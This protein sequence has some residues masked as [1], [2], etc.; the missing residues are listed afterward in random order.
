M[1]WQR[2]TPIMDK[3]ILLSELTY[4]TS[5]SGGAGG[6][7]VNKVETK[8]EAVFDIQASIALTAVEKT[9]LFERLAHKLTTDGILGVVNQTDRSQLT[10]KEKAQKKL[11]LLIES[12]LEP[13]K[14][15]KPTRVPFAIKVTIRKNK[16]MQSDKKANRKNPNLDQFDFR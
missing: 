13:I 6:Q 7:H 10:N 9:I 12:A 16:A 11:I 4:R 5:R 14:I 1:T 3:E 15:R 8:V 2:K